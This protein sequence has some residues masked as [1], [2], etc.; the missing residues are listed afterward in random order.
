MAKIKLE[1]IS[2]NSQ[3]ASLSKKE[4]IKQFMQKLQNDQYNIVIDSE[5]E[6]LE[7]KYKPWWKSPYFKGFIVFLCLLAFITTFAYFFIT[8]ANPL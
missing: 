1:N 6:N 2:W 8:Y 4:A 5:Y 7:E 3:E